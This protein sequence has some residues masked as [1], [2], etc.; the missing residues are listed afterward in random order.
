M[1][2]GHMEYITQTVGQPPES[3]EPVSGGLTLVG[4]YKVTVHGRDWMV[5][6]VP[7]NANREMWYEAL[8]Q[9]ADDRMANPKQ[10]KRFEDGTLCLFAPWIVGDSL[11]TILVNATASEV[12][13]YGKQ[14]SELLKKLHSDPIEFPAAGQSML[15]RINTA[16]EQVEALKLT[17]PGH[18]KCCEFLRQAGEEHVF[19]KV[20]ILH[21]DIRPE[22]L[23]VLNGQLHLIDFENGGVG[24]PAEDFAYLMTMG[25]PEHRAFSRALTEYYLQG[26]DAEKFWQ[27]NLLYSTLQVV[28][29]A[30]WKWHRK[31]RQVYHQAK[32]LMNQYDDLTAGI[33]K[34]WIEGE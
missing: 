20:S 28:E 15:K 24:E 8:K 9:R 3:V 21:K 31:G 32:N 10:F 29:Y 13:A 23:I 22:N 16:C 19:G 17:F 34:W 25:R 27:D 26:Q 1:E 2:Q 4:K 30:I 14:A 6:I 18:E 33:P 7:G 5:K 12:Q 11:E